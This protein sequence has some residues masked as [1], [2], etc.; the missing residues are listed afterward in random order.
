MVIEIQEISGVFNEC[1]G[2]Q[3]DKA[4]LKK[5][6]EPIFYLSRGIGID[7]IG[8]ECIG[9]DCYAIA[10]ENRYNRW[11]IPYCSYLHDKNRRVFFDSS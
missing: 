7:P 3:F 9:V 6:C 4:T 10:K 8:A 5:F 11:Q 1:K 2:T